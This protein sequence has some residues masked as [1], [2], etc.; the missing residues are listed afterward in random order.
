SMVELRN[1]F[2]DRELSRAQIRDALDN[3]SLQL[4]DRPADPGMWE[5]CHPYQLL[6][7]QKH[8]NRPKR[9]AQPFIESSSTILIVTPDAELL[10]PLRG[11]HVYL[12]PE[13]R[14]VSLH[15]HNQ[16]EPEQLL[17]SIA[18]QFEWGEITTGKLL[19]IGAPKNHKSFARSMTLVAVT[20]QEAE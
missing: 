9:G 2:A 11:R 7:M 5:L 8:W 15:I 20:E 13:T 17:K 4:Q 10:V 18:S 14:T 12:F 19:P 3:L 6:L 16:Q 1:R